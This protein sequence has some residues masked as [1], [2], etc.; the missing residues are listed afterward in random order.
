MT[1]QTL[2]TGR[3]A[4]SLAAQYLTDQ[5]WEIVARNFRTRGAELD[6]VGLDGQTLVFVEV[7][8]RTT[9]SM[10]CPEEAVDARKI[11]KLHQAAE[12]FLKVRPEYALRDCRFDVI[13]V[14]GQ[15]IL[16]SLRH[17]K[18]VVCL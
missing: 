3:K 17:I 12:S 4:E 10:G 8:A 16:A 15:G 7:K 13:A 1:E 11:H 9:L 2:E 6:V 18:D 14:E 5:G